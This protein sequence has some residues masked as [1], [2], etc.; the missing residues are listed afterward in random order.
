[1]EKKSKCV[2]RLFWKGFNQLQKALGFFTQKCCNSWKKHAE[3]ATVHRNSEQLLMKSTWFLNTPTWFLSGLWL[4][5]TS[6]GDWWCFVLLVCFKCLENHLPSTASTQATKL[7]LAMPQANNR[8][9]N[10]MHAMQQKAETLKLQKHNQNY[11]QSWITKQ[12]WQVCVLKSM[13]T[14]CNKFGSAIA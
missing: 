5:V 14:F 11:K 9:A 2:I 13:S 8:Q 3:S 4:I 6:T 12:S 7:N 1:M 10:K